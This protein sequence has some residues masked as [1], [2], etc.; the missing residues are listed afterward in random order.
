MSPS[1]FS[2][3]T[4][5]INFIGTA[6]KLWYVPFENSLF[7]RLNQAAYRMKMPIAKAILDPDFYAI[8]NDKS[9]ENI[10]SISKRCVW[11][12]MLDEKSFV[13]LRINGRRKRKILVKEILS[14]DL[15]FPLFNIDFL[16]FS[17]E[18]S[19]SILVVEKETGLAAC[20]KLYLEKL[21]LDFLRFQFTHMLIGQ[22]K[23]TALSLI[24]YKDIALQSISKDTLV[25]GHYA[26]IID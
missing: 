12:L 8:M 10:D 4:T 15:L 5:T 26:M 23:I 25:T 20:F 2:E 11:G 22:E 3:N 24:T 21:N 16:E 19:G 13:E 14:E 17:P 7:N 1:K 18:L 6:C 9:N